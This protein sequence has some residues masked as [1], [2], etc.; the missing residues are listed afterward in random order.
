MSDDTIIANLYKE[1]VRLKELALVLRNALAEIRD[2]CIC[3]G[4]PLNDNVGGYTFEQRKDWHEINNIAEC[5]L[6]EFDSKD[7]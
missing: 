5:A 2:N 6:S 3:V 7:G 4:R 1:N